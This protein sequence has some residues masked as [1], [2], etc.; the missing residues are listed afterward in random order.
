MCY[1]GIGKEAVLKDCGDDYNAC[2]ITDCT[3]VV[4]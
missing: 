3:T 2:Y 1:Q 4:I